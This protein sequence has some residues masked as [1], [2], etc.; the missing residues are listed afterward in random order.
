MPTG[1]IDTLIRKLRADK[2][3]QSIQDFWGDPLTAA[4]A[5]SNDGKA[6]TVQVNLAGNQGEPLANESVEAVRKIVAAP[7]AAG[8]QRLGHRG[9]GADRRSAC[10]AATNP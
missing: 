9:V 3:V 4:G 2:H 5:Q 1:F 7:A 8:S 10:T 6:A